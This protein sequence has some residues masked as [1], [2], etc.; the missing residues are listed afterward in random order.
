MVTVDGSELDQ[1]EV[2]FVEGTVRRWLSVEWDPRPAIRVAGA[3]DSNVATFIKSGGGRFLRCS[4]FY[5]DFVKT[6][7]TVHATWAS[8]RRMVSSLVNGLGDGTFPT[9]AQILD[10]G[11]EYLRK[12]LRLGFRSR[13]LIESTRLLLDDGTV[14]ERGDLL[15]AAIAFEDLL[16]LRGVGEYTA[17]HV[18]ML[19]GDFSRVPVDSEVTR[20]CKTRYGIEPK[21]VDSFF[22]RWGQYRF[23]GY[24]ISRALS[25]H[26]E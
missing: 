4:T 16:R 10:H 21:E 20:F 6:V 2:D 8:T 1:H 12:H 22:D 25:D 11:E 19:L 15:D 24:K 14:D 3:I 7:C 17:S 18:M 9:P 5:E 23:L 26:V 13:V